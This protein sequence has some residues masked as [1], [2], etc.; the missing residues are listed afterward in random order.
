MV[1]GIG[2]LAGR[3]GAFERGRNLGHAHGDRNRNLHSRSDRQR[4]A[5]AESDGVG[6]ADDLGFRAIDYVDK[7]RSGE[8]RQL[9]QHDAERDGRHA[10]IHMVDGIGQPA[11]GPDAF[12][13]RRNFGDADGDRD[14]NFHSRS[15]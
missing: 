4:I 2:Q 14:R 7:F 9:L 15:Q 13:C 8:E 1:A 10:W 12:G 3:A 11:R 6:V 5:C